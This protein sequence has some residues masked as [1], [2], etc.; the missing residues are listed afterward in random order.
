MYV[1]R[2]ANLRFGGLVCLPTNNQPVRKFSHQKTNQTIIDSILCTLNS[3][4]LMFK[5]NNQIKFFQ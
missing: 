2:Y 1:F 4:F 3:K 5:Y